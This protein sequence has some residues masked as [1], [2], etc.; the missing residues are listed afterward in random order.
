MPVCVMMLMTVAIVILC[1]LQNRVR[2]IETSD[3]KQYFRNRSFQ[4]VLPD[5]I[6]SD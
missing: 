2:R 5:L 1:V 4:A 6:I 3:S